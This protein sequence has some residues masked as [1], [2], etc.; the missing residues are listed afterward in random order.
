MLDS[1]A[2]IS[3]LGKNAINLTNKLDLQIFSYN[4]SVRTA[5]GKPHSVIG[6]V[7]LPI[8][9]NKTTHIIETLLVPSISSEL[10]LGMDFWTAFEIVPVIKNNN[11][12]ISTVDSNQIS[13]T[14]EQQKSL[15]ET[16]SK[17]LISNEETP[18]G[19]TDVLSH[20][21]DTGTAVP[22]KQRYYPVSPYIQTEIDAELERMVKLDVIE[23]SFSPWSSPVVSVRKPNGK[24]RLCLDSRMLNSK[25][26]KD[27]Y[28]LP[29]ITRILSQLSETKYISTLD[30]KDAFWQIPL[31]E[32]SKEKTAFTIPSRGL[33]QF[34]VM[35]FGLH[36]A[37]QTQSR[38]MDQ[39]MGYDLEPNV[40]YYI[41]DLIITSTTFE[42]HIEL[43]EEVSK[44]LKKAKLRI[45]LEKSKFCVREVPYLG[46]ILSENGLRLDQE[47]IAPVLNF[48]PPTTI[49]GLRRFLGMA[50]WYRRFIG[51]FA[52]LAAPLTE[53]TKGSPKVIKFTEE[54]HEAFNKIKI[55]LT[56]APILAMPDFSKEFQVQSDASDKAVGAVLTQVQDEQEVVIAYMSQKLSKTQEKY[57]VTEKECLALILAIEKW[58]GYLEGAP[59]FTAITDHASLQ[60]L[61]NLKDPAGRL[62]RWA[63]RL[64]PY[65]FKLIHRKGTLNVVPDF[66]S[67]TIASLNV[68]ADDFTGDA[69][70]DELLENI[71]NDP[72]LYPKYRITDNKIFKNVSLKK[73]SDWKLYVP[74]QLRQKVLVDKHDTVLAAHQGY[75]RTLARIKQLY[76]W[77][78]LY[79]D[80]KEYVKRCEVCK[81]CKPVNHAMKAKMGKPKLPNMPWRTISVDLMG[82]FPRSRDGNIFL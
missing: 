72:N 80:V 54:A 41:D 42:K 33:W 30:L 52:K 4:K 81:Q 22:I 73:N 14:P 37:A 58:R 5:D 64:Q 71:L 79:V 44:R 6:F 46:Y 3:V 34:K 66:L 75:S 51:D 68:E 48:P 15:D 27:S 24:L 43:L 36:N 2:N 28:P 47:K 63:L 23:R 67:R 32:S 31:E 35:P 16:I 45:S 21:I 55:A 69:E 78:K 61:Q 82:P 65:N 49:K 70:Y 10:I 7:Y 25:T 53:L 19:R 60:W 11:I 26:V 76:Y 57:S 18:L 29:Y 39:V 56:S 62:A 59:N 1:G 8:S 17:F 12:Q 77:P 40:H 74:L 50:N 13:I 38:L 20:K 9:F